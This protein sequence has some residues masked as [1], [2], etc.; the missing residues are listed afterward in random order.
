VNFI[1]VD[2]EESTAII[3]VDRIRWIESHDKGACTIWFSET[4]SIGIPE[5]SAT[6]FLREAFA[7]GTED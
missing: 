1:T 6:I 7:P 5:K 2:M 3:N 4:H